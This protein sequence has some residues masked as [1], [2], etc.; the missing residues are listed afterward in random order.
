MN[1]A[2]KRN[3]KD[4]KG[5]RSVNITVHTV[6]KPRVYLRR[7]LIVKKNKDLIGAVNCYV[8]LRN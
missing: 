3:Y 8:I 4:G 5:K 6:I 2:D 7:R 1:T